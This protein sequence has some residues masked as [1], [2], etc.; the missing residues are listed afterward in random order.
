MKTQK[1]MISL[2]SNIAF[3]YHKYYFLMYYPMSFFVKNTFHNLRAKELLPLILLSC[4]IF[5]ILSD[6]HYLLLKYIVTLHSSLFLIERLSSNKKNFLL[7]PAPSKSSMG[8]MYCTAFVSLHLKLTGSKVST[9]EG[10]YSYLG[11]FLSFTSHNRGGF[12]QGD[13]LSL[14]S[15]LVVSD[16]VFADD[17]L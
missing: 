15:C 11:G 16:T 2:V 3:I 14:S 13:V 9:L 10:I 5:P 1:C 6:T 17:R 12:L 7:P 4:S 8:K